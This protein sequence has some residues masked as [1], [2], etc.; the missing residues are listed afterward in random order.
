MRIVATYVWSATKCR[1]ITLLHSRSQVATWRCSG[2]DPLAG[3]DVEGV[4]LV[5]TH[6]DFLTGADRSISFRVVPSGG[7]AG[8]RGLLEVAKGATGSRSKVVCDALI[9]DEESRSDTYP[10]IAIDEN[11][12]D[13]GHEAT[14][15]KI[16]DEQTL[17]P[18]VARTVPIRSLRDDRRRC[19]R[20]D[21]QRTPARVR[22]RHELPDPD[23]DGR[24][25]GETYGSAAEPSAIAIK[26]NRTPGFGA[27]PPQRRASSM[28]AFA[29]NVGFREKDLESIE[30]TDT[31]GFLVPLQLFLK[32]IAKVDL[33]TAAQE[34]QLAKQIERGDHRAKQ[35]MVAANLRLVVSIAKKYR[36]RGLPFGT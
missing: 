20:T 22:D 8:Y 13:V 9:L 18:H 19:R 35:Q 25:G 7:R 1:E 36:G 3:L 23:P 27:A 33:L 24:L 12:V 10:Y 6:S 2:S 21:R 16:G 14:V 30:R 31:D 5:H 29:G 26:L 32:D 34:V 28:S 15:S 17:L 11:E 4:D